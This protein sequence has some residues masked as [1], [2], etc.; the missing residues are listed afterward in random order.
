MFVRVMMNLKGTPLVPRAFVLLVNIALA[1]ETA[2]SVSA[3]IA[4]PTAQPMFPVIAIPMP[5]TSVIIPSAPITVWRT[6]A[7]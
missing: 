6:E 4:P 7:R 5:M 1:P 2:S 3:A